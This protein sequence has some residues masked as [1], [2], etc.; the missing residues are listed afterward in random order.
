MIYLFQD[1]LEYMKKQRVI[2]GSD[3]ST[4]SSYQ[5]IPERQNQKEM[6]PVACG[7]INAL[8]NLFD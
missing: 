4:M 5:D 8:G 7:K 3:E 6:L 2:E 1:K